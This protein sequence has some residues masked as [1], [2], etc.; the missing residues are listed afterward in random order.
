MTKTKMIIIII[1]SAIFISFRYANNKALVL[2]FKEISYVRYMNTLI[3][4]L[5]TFLHK[6]GKKF[7]LLIYDN[8]NNM[9]ANYNLPITSGDKYAGQKSTILNGK[10]RTVVT[11]PFQTV[12]QD[13]ISSNDAVDIVIVYDRLRQYEDIVKGNNVTK[14]F[15]ANSKKDIENIMTVKSVGMDDTSFIITNADNSFEFKDGSPNFGKPVQFLDIPNLG[16]DFS[17]LSDSA[18]F[19]KYFRLKTARTGVPLMATIIKKAHIEVP[20]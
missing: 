2:Y 5:Y 4:L 10:Y 7:V 6:T 11:E 9:V 8:N 20:R 16:K 3:T 14:F 1:K 17:T 15:V 13:A 19:N 18:K 12:I